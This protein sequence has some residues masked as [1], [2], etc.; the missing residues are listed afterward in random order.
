MFLPPYMPYDQPISAAFFHQS[1]NK[2]MGDVTKSLSFKR[3][4]FYTL[5]F[6]LLKPSIFFKYHQAYYSKF[7]HGARFAFSVLYGIRTDSDFCC[8]LY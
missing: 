7:L 3:V 5:F 8:A 2:P 1:T 6:N 4:V